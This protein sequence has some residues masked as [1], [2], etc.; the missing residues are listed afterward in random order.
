MRKKGKW[1]QKGGLWDTEA[2]DKMGL[3]A[4]PVKSTDS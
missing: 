2:A 4:A 3:S 1:K